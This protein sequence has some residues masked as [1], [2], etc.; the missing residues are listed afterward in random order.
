MSAFPHSLPQTT[1]ISPTNRLSCVKLTG[2]FVH[3]SQ[4]FTIST[5]TIDCTMLQVSTFVS[6]ETRA[7]LLENKH[8]D[9]WRDAEYFV[10]SLAA[11]DVAVLQR[12]KPCSYAAKGLLWQEKWFF[13]KIVVQHLKSSCNNCGHMVCSAKAKR[14]YIQLCEQ[15]DFL[16]YKQ[17]KCHFSPKYFLSFACTKD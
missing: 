16:F 14:Q 5:V 6:N 9:S 7:V 4:Y 13:K 11:D 8:V 17:W 2:N 3:A 10:N 12:E 1:F 15:R